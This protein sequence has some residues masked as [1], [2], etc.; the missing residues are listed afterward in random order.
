MKS[1]RHLLIGVLVLSAAARAA[2]QDTLRFRDP[3]RP[4]MTGEITAMNFRT[5]EIE[6]EVGGLRVPQ[7][8]NAREILEIEI[9]PG[10]K[11]H[12]FYAGE[13]AMN[14]GDLAKAAERFELAK[15]D[16][17][18]VIKQTAG[19]N[20]IR[21]H[22]NN[23]DIPAALNAI[24]A[25]RQEK[26]ETYYLR[27]TYEYEYRCHLQRGDAG[28]MAR[29]ADDF[30]KKGKSE[31]LDEWAKSAELMRAQLREFQ[32]KWAEALG[33]YSRYARDREIGDEAAL[34]ELRCLTQMQNW[35][36]LKAKAE[37]VI[38]A[39]KG[40][41]GSERL[42]MGAYNARGEALLRA[43]NPKEALFD[44]MQ[45]V[46]VLSQ[47]GETCREHERALALA[48]IACAQIATGQ[49]NP[50]YKERARELLSD[51]DKIYSNSPLRAELDKAIREI[52]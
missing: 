25:F 30:E 1:M 36:P 5:V 35:S 38:S 33:I 44:F 21:C 7:K 10:R 37:T 2:A 18:E 19:M 40:K 27:E 14:R 23:G 11:S 47:G 50:V 22:F 8:V 51:L 13:E 45:G 49:K 15:R 16:P 39:H 17:R 41:K 4:R 26:P 42:L 6:I 29:T 20:V 24:K 43:G 9:D 46:A 48:G 28:A 31:K 52:R 34:G 32:G 3:G 12:D